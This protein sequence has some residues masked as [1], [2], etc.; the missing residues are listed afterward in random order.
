MCQRSNGGS[1]RGHDSRPHVAGHRR[2][3]WHTNGAIRSSAA[4]VA[5]VVLSAPL[6]AVAGGLMHAHPRCCWLCWIGLPPPPP[7]CGEALRPRLGVSP[8]GFCLFSATFSSPCASAVAHA[9]RRTHTNDDS[10]HEQC[11]PP[12]LQPHLVQHSPPVRTCTLKGEE[13]QQ[14]AVDDRMRQPQ[15]RSGCIPVRAQGRRHGRL[16]SDDATAAQPQ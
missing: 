16:R 8:F 14:R 6:L 11:M 1:W 15:R 12:K 3:Q 4:V 10:S 2:P 5:A 13:R 7:P 9:P